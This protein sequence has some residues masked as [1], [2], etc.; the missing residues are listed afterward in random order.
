MIHTQIA[1]EFQRL[2]AR[3]QQITNQLQDL[4]DG[5]L[6]YS[7]T[8]KYSKWYQSTS[9]GRTYI[10]KSNRSFAEKLALKTY[11]SNLRNDYIAELK[12]LKHYLDH[13][14]SSDTEQTFLSNPIFHELLAPHFKPLSSELDEWA[15]A[16]YPSNPFPNK[17]STLI[18]P[19]GHNVRSKSEL[20]IAMAFLVEEHRLLARGIQ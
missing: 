2:N 12:L 10:P 13:H 17:F 1:N 18:S 15:K 5:K 7:Q 8:G 9:L 14:I 20:L 16:P 19:S 4:P 6:T 11:L 3:I